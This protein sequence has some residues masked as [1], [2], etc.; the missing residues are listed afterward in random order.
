MSSFLYDK[1]RES[2]ML[3]AF[4]LAS[5][6]I[7]VALVRIGVSHYV[8]SQSGDQFLSA[9]AGGDILSTTANLASKTTTAGVFDAADTLFAAV[10]AGPAGGAIVIYQDTG[11]SSTSRLIAYIDSY[12]GLP[13]TPNNA[14]ITL[15]WP[16]SSDK[17][18]KL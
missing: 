11:S 5:D 9:I 12:A 14:D 4:D 6:N 8:A 3:G 18:F 10:T 13:V 1:A 2:F 15:T 7:K 16:T 17:I